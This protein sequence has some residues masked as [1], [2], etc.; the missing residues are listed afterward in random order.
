MELLNYKINYTGIPW[1]PSL[2]G[3]DE[4]QLIIEQ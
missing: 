2:E 4:D 1:P 3:E